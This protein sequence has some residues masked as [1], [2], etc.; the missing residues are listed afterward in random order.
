MRIGITSVFVDDQTKAL[1][2]YT[3]RLGFAPKLDIPLGE[4]RWLTVVDPDQPDGVQLLLEPL[5]Q[6]FAVEFQRNLKS[7]GIPA[8]LFFVDDVEAEHARLTGLG[9]AFTTP[10]TQIPGGPKIAVLDDT[11]GNLIQLVQP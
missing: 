9:V 7:A 1:A 5:G 2:F 10:P 4:H 6:P 8:T 11:C 3:E